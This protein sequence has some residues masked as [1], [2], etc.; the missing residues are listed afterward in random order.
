MSSRR[1]WFDRS[2]PFLREREELPFSSLLPAM[3]AKYNIFNCGATLEL[4]TAARVHPEQC[5]PA[6]AVRRTFVSDSRNAPAVTCL[7]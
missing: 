6:A 7:S 5:S 3:W 2:P 4:S 1:M